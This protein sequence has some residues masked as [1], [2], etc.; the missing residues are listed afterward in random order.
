MIGRASISIT[1]PRSSG[2]MLVPCWSEEATLQNS[3][4]KY[5]CIHRHDNYVVCFYTY[6][7]CFYTCIHTYL[8]TYIPTYLHTYTPTYLHTYI[9]KSLHRK[10]LYTYV[11]IHICGVQI[12]IVKPHSLQKSLTS[13]LI[14]KLSILRLERG[15]WG[16]CLSEDGVKA[17]A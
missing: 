1:D 2:Y 14:S 6:R 15:I 10:S 13:Y 7:V 3:I 12:H 5:T 17:V 9:H 11:Y 8:H 16:L 4:L